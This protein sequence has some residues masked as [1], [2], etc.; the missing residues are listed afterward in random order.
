MDSDQSVQFNGRTYR[1]LATLRRAQTILQKAMK[2]NERRIKYMQKIGG[3]DKQNEI[4]AKRATT[5]EY[6]KMGIPQYIESDKP[7][8]KPRSERIKKYEAI[9]YNKRQ[10]NIVSVENNAVQRIKNI[11]KALGNSF[12]NVT[13]EDEDFNEEND[14]I[15]LYNEYKFQADNE[16]QLKVMKRILYL[17]NIENMIKKQLIKYFLQETKYKVIANIVIKYQMFSLSTPVDDI[18]IY[19]RFFNS[20]SETLLG[21]NQIADFF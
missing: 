4:N 14:L 7:I 21:V 12:I 3:V 10:P 18:K 16:E 6:N 20:I 11:K 8:Q 2:K 19:D 17:H 13:L 1:S 9:Y 5:K 15:E